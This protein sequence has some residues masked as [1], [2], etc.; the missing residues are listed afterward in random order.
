VVVYQPTVNALHLCRNALPV[1]RVH[2]DQLELLANPEHQAAPEMTALQARPLPHVLKQTFHARAA[3]PD[4][5]DLLAQTAVPDHPDQMVSQV[6][7]ELVEA[8][9]HPDQQDLPVMLAPAE[10]P[11]NQELPDSQDK[12]VLDPHL[13]QDQKAQVVAQDQQAPAD[14]TET[15]DNQ[16][17]LAHQ[18]QQE[19]QEIQVNLEAMDSPAKKAEMVFQVRTLPTALAPDVHQS[20]STV[21]RLPTLLPL[22]LLFFKTQKLKTDFLEDGL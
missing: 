10:A 16:E 11:D 18:D 20:L 9:D 13:L 17:A 14:P 21:N 22:L 6:P 2:P 1:H 15:Q 8:K 5:P 7:Q 12:T 19:L 4:H 3:Q